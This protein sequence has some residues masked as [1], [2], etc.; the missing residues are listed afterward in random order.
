MRRTRFAWLACAL[1]GSLTLVLACGG[2]GGMGGDDVVADDAP[3]I[4][5][6]PG[7]EPDADNSGWTELIAR[8]W[9]IVPGEDYRCI[10]IAVEE[11]LYITDFRALSPNGTHHTVLTVADGG[12]LGEDD[13]CGAGTLDSE[14]LFASGVGTDDLSFPDGVAIKIAA[15]R[16]IHL[17]LHLFNTQP[18]GSI[19]GRSGIL[20]KT[21]PSVTPDKEA[22]MFFAG[23]FLIS[24]PANS[25]GNASGNCDFDA[26]S[27][28]L[29][30]WPHMHQ[31]G[32]HQRVTL[33]IDGV[34]QVLHDEAFDFNE[35]TNYRLDPEIQVSA[36][37]NIAVTCTYNNTSNQT[38]TFGDSSEQE[39]C[40]TGL[41]RYPKQGTDI[42][43][44]A[45]PF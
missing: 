2:G 25:T 31:Y 10:R 37:D 40:F 39:M 29:A 7:E 3:D 41:Y 5:A 9:S 35:Q 34:Q 20:V 27:T 17:N 15:G 1:I 8:D 11:D 24:I 36:G 18:S 6:R 14:M 33:T 28:L 26:A 13:N 32:T 42:F 44:C 45:Q 4:D 43:E 21:V 12:T 23:T 38:V 16:T 30:Y 19:D 22:E